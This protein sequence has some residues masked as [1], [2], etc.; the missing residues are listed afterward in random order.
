MDRQAHDPDF[1][2]WII[3]LLIYISMNEQTDSRSKFLWMDRQAHD[4]DFYGWA[5][6]F[7]IQISMDGQTGS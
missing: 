7:M 5:N 1:Y 4:L 3:R 2:G 6:R